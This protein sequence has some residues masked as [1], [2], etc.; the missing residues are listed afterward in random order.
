MKISFNWLKEYI[1]TDL[2][3][4]EVSR[5]LTDTGLEVEG[6]EEFQSIKGGLEGIVVGK[7]LTKEKHPDADRLSVTTVDVGTDIPLDIVC[8]APNVDAGQTVLVATVG[9]TLYDGDEN[10]KIKKSKIR[11]KASVGM[12][13]AEDE[14]GLGDSHDGIMVLPNDINAGTLAKDYFKIEKDYTIEIGLTPNRIDGASHYGAARDFAAFL[15]QTQKVELSKPNVDNFKIDNTKR[16]IDVIVEDVNLCPRYTGITISNIKVQDSPEWLQNR[17]KSIGLKPINNIVDI[18][19]FVLHELG[20]PLH[21][22]DADKIIGDKVYVKTLEDKTKFITLD[23]AERELSDKDLMICNEKEGMCIAGVFGGVDSGVKNETK[24]IFLESAYFNAVSVRKT[25][26]YHGLNTDASF[27]FERGTDPNN[28]VYALKRAA[29]LIKELAGGEISSEIIDIYPNKIV[30]NEISVS[31]LNIARLIGKNLGDDIIKNILISLD[32]EIVKEE[33]GV[34]QLKIPTY[35][36]DVTREADVIEEILRIYGYDNIEI[37]TNVNSTISYSQKP[38]KEKLI[39]VISDLLVGNGFSEMMANSLTKADYINAVKDFDS[40]N[41]VMIL[42]PLSSDLNSLRQTLLFGGLEAI[43]RNANR[44]NQNLRLFEFGNVYSYAKAEA[45]NNLDNYTEN[46]HLSLFLTG[47][48]TKQSWAVGTEKTSFYQMK[49][50]V[51]KIFERLGFIKNKFVIDSTSSNIFDEGLSYKFNNKLFLDFG[52]VSEDICKKLDVNQE[53]FFADFYWDNIIAEIQKN[54]VEFKALPKYP[55]V[56]RDL[57]LLL[58]KSVT[59]KQIKELAEK[60]E[61]KLLKE[62]DLFDVYSGKN[63]DSNKKSYALSFILQDENKTLNDKQIDKVMK[64]LINR[65]ER[66]FN[67]QIR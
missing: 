61:R 23:E 14:L 29:L 56:K 52:S 67:A 51:E 10:F 25:A 47:D 21:A 24:N 44:R 34:L 42:N 41:N 31:Y 39:N 36:V 62:V 49:S 66:E 35:R 53:V 59:F 27:R 9:T 54:K 30:E 45:E 6:I 5:I 65:F 7:V 50:F 48:K 16:T 3:I 46:K 55:Q 2:S 28:T 63:I 38:D 19:N 15:M 32:I 8:G 40:D 58:D 4:D 26:K 18:T 57:A 11:G 13:C 22:F 60:S 43:S 12:I 20:Q 1:K 33:D 37:S 64:N 17:L